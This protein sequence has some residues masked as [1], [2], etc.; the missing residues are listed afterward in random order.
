M[1]AFL[2]VWSSGALVAAAVA[3]FL[4]MRRRQSLAIL[5]PNLRREHITRPNR[6]LPTAY[7]RYDDLRDDEDTLP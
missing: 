3:V 5:V 7:R 6:P 1:I 2:L 4:A